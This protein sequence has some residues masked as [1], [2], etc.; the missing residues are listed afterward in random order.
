MKAERL[1][2]TNI[3]LHRES[4]G[5]T[6][7]EYRRTMRNIENGGKR[8]D[9]QKRLGGNLARALAM[10][11][12]LDSEC[13]ALERGEKH[14]LNT[15]LGEYADWYYGY[16][17]KEAVSRF[18][19]KPG[20]LGWKT[21]QSN[22]RVFVHHV[23]A[24]KPLGRINPG[25]VQDFL[26]MRKGSVEKATVYGSLRDVRRMF[27]VAIKK[28]HLKVNPCE[29]LVVEKG[30]DKEPRLPTNEEV[31][32]L[33]GYLKTHSPSLYGIVLTLVFTAGRLGEVITLDW[34]RVDC[35]NGRLTLVRRKV[36]DE[37]TLNMAEPLRKHLESLWKDGNMPIRGLVFPNPT[38]GKPDTRNQVYRRFKR[39]AERLGLGWLT[40]KI[41]RK[42]AA[43]LV[44]EAT[45]NIRDA[46]M[47]LGHGDSHTTEIYLRGGNT[48]ARERA[49]R[50]LEATIGR[51]VGNFVGNLPTEEARK[52]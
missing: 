4:D 12:E 49:V 41:F 30:L 10:A 33:L 29:G 9:V 19:R 27:N 52:N 21:I 11:K 31:E 17:E 25:L 23:G 48:A 24:E 51:T 47:I 39:V 50:A 46:Q 16:I 36:N 1:E 6:R 3:H 32:R 44:Q 15:P 18:S 7:Y 22:L 26:D 34:F 5:K 14:L 35:M 2:G 28:G 13:D 20:L 38:T 43:T 40:L 8:K 45:G 42:Y 37:L